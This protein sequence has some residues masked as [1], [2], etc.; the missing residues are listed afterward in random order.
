M[1]CGIGLTRGCVVNAKPTKGQP[2]LTLDSVQ[3]SIHGTPI[4]SDVSFQIEAGQTLG[5]IGES[6][7][8]K[9]MTALSIMQLLPRGAELQGNIHFDGR[10]LNTLSEEQLCDLRGSDIGMIFQ[11]P[12]T[13]LNP[14]KTI[15]D[16]VSESIRLHRRVSAAEAEQLTAQTLERVG[17]PNSEFPLGRYPHELSG[18]QRQ[19]VVIAI[20]VAC[21]P[22]LLIADEPTTALDVTTQAG[23]LDLLKALQRDEGLALMLITHDL[24]VVSNM[25]DDVVVMK[26][27]QVVEQGNL[28]AVFRNPSNPYTRLLFDASALTQISRSKPALSATAQLEADE[29]IPL[30]QV[31][32]LICEYKGP[33]AGFFKRPTSFRAVND[34]SFDIWHGESI[35]L[36]GESGCG[37]ST[38]S[39]ALLG[40]MKLH[41]GTVLLNGESVSAAKE[42]S[43]A[44]RQQMQVVFQDPYGSFNPRQKVERLIS[45][46]LFLLDERLSKAQTQILVQNV[47]ESVGM[48]HKDADKFIH[49]FSGGQRQR[50]AIARALIIKPSLIILDEAVSALDVSV[51]AQV[52]ELLHDLAQKEGL[53]YLFISHDLSV[54]QRV[55]D[56]VLVMEKGKIVERGDTPMVFAQPQHPYTQQLIAAAPTLSIPDK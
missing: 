38:L 40:L 50:I 39:K 14:V 19:R 15:G 32:N 25:A 35:G 28:G 13:A 2:L 6:G 7:S 53:A 10:S 4:L 47:L 52:L 12:M 36:V 30:L 41:S 56:R 3:L 55:S 44:A 18:G 42:V 9:S 45:E 20:A 24:A 51:R 8:G 46:P 33:R 54:V 21:Q 17:L 22:K 1:V 43:R 11:E 23:I 49:E 34:I 29:P 31:N 26:K 48:N 37:K 16:Q 5:V 27:G